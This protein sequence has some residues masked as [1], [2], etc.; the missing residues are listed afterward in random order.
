M[1]TLNDLTGLV[2]EAQKQ[3][4]ATARDAA[5]LAGRTLE[6]NLNL[7]ERV[8]AFQRDAFL[9]YAGVFEPQAQ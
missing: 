1:S 2:A 8:L 5:A 6:A 9:R 3:T 4:L 7:A